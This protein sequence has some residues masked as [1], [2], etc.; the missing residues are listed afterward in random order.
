MADSPTVLINKR[1][2]DLGI[3]YSAIGKKLGMSKQNFSRLMS[4]GFDIKL[5]HLVKICAAYDWNL[6]D[7]I[8][9]G[10]KPK[11]QLNAGLCLR[12]YFA[13]QALCALIQKSDIDNIEFN[14][15][16]FS[17]YCFSDWMMKAR[18][19]KALTPEDLNKEV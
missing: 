19:S 12:D 9:L 7:F 15:V 6:G 11:E 8:Q 1:L 3:S 17:S 2:K 16:A 10:Q 13:G 18:I 4:Q 5:S 14:E